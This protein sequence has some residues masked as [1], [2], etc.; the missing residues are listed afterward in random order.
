[1]SRFEAGGLC[2]FKKSGQTF[3]MY[4]SSL[5]IKAFLKE[6]TEL[7]LNYNLLLINAFT[8]MRTFL[9]MQNEKD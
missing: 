1:M 9:H 2:L 4:F 8:R 5:C 7:G 6:K 3:V